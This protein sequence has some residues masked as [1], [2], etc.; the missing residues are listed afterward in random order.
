MSN[1]THGYH[2][3]MSESTVTRSVTTERDGDISIVRIDDGKANALGHQVIDDLGAA[4]DQAVGDARAVVIVGRPDRFSAG[5]DLA[6]MRGGSDAV[7]GLVGAGARL[8]ARIYTLEIP[9]V[10]ACTGHA[11]A[12]GAI[13]LMASDLR[14][15]ADGDY[16]IGLPEVTLGMVL[17]QFAVDLAQ[18]RLSRRHL[19]AATMHGRVYSPVD[20]TDA[21]FLDQVVAPD[22]VESEARAAAAQ[23]AESVNPRAFA[24]TRR[25]VRAAT[26][27]KILSELDADLASFF[28]DQ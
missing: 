13:L 4:L 27:D 5:F 23:L 7:T 1:V 20:A 17:P 15:G 12:A 3:V 8:F 6:V 24:A 16:K 9:V 14:I 11:L 28:V 10:A 25:N 19:T 22:Q 21:G 26:A 18:D 2:R